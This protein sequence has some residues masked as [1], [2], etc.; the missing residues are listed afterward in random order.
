MKTRSDEHIS[1]QFGNWGRVTNLENQDFR[2]N[3]DEPFLIINEADEDVYL[4]VINPKYELVENVRF[5]QGGNP[6]LIRRIKQYT[7]SSNLIWGN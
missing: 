7:G 1:L 5:R 4:D 3:N 2:L 6:L